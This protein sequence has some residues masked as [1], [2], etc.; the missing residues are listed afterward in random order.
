MPCTVLNPGDR[1]ASKT[2]VCFGLQGADGRSIQGARGL[3]NLQMITKPSPVGTQALIPKS[4]SQNWAC[5]L[6]VLGVSLLSCR[7]QALH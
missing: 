4:R 7:M 5:G 2:Q 3:V 1:V 6:W